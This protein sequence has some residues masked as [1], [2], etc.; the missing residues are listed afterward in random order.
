MP[1][2]VPRHEASNAELSRSHIANEELRQVLGFVVHEG[3]GGGVKEEQHRDRIDQDCTVYDLRTVFDAPSDAEGAEAVTH[4][5]SL[6]ETVE[7]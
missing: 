7:V 4:K 1:A 6:R 5:G 2:E 3:G